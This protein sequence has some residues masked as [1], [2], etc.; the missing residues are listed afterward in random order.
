MEYEAG[1][2][3]FAAIAPV[4]RTKSVLSNETFRA[5]LAGLP[6]FKPIE[7]F[8]QD[9]SSSLLAALLISNI[10]WEGS[11]VFLNLCLWMRIILPKPRNCTGKPIK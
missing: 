9:T 8:D 7:I 4:T 2:T 11:P 5:T 10:G 6:Y 3:V 1:H